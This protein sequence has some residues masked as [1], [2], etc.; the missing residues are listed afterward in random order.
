MIHYETVTGL[1]DSPPT[2]ARR[3]HLAGLYSHRSQDHLLSLEPSRFDRGARSRPLH[4]PLGRRAAFTRPDNY[5]GEKK[6]RIVQYN[7]S[8]TR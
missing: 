4:R 8:C 1:T 5:H 2:A 7:F 6:P 3:R